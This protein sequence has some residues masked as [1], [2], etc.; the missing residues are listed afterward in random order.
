MVVA[1]LG[2]L[3]ISTD[4]RS[5]IPDVRV[6]SSLMGELGCACVTVVAQWIILAP[7]LS[8]VI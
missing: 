6:R 1:D 5:K 7:V 4:L 2:S 8:K 3:R